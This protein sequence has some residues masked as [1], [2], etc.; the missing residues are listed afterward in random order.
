MLRKL[1]LCL[2]A[3]AVRQSVEK[4]RE[5]TNDDVLPHTTVTNGQVCSKKWTQIYYLKVYLTQRIKITFFLSQSIFYYPKAGT[6]TAVDN[7]QLVGFVS[8][9]L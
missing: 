1:D 7:S 4:E 3:E 8:D 2:A 9:W 5:H 6:A